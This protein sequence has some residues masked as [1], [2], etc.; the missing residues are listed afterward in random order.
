MKIFT[1]IKTLALVAGMMFATSNANAADKP[2]SGN[3]VVSKVFYAASKGAES[4][5][6][7][8]GQYIEIYNNSANDVDVTGLYIGLIESESKST[9]YTV[10]AIEADADLKTKLNGKV[11]LKQVFQLPTEET[12]I[13]QPGKSILVCNSAIDH[14]ALA[15][16]GHDLSGADY[17]VKTTNAKYTHNDD[18]PALTM[19]YSFNS[20]TD[21][22]NLSYAGPAGVVLL[23]NDAKAIDFENPI[24][25][26]GK[27]KGSQYVIANM[28]YSVDAV[29][30]LANNKTSGIDVTTKRLTDTND[31]GYASTATGGTYNGETV[32]R[33]TAFVMPDGRKVLYDTNNS[34]VDF[35]SSSTIQP[36]AYD[37]ELSGVTEASITIP[38]TG[39]LVFRPETSVF[40]ESDLTF[41]YVTANA[42]NSDLTYNEFKGTDELLANTNF[43]VIGQPGTHKVYYSEAQAS[44]KIPSNAL[45][46]SDED[47]KEF[48]SASQKTRIIY[49][50]V[51]TTEKTGFQRVA[52]TAEGLYN[53]AEFSGDDRLYLYITPAMAT[54][55]FAANGAD[56]ADNLDFLVWHGKKPDLTGVKTVDAAVK[57]TATGA[58]YDINGNKVNLMQKGNVYI[59]D[60]KKVL[61]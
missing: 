43:I 55:F 7:A 19:A 49:K 5:N 33:K 9:A 54:A 39:Y 2:S 42:K 10:E 24:Y 58:I 21:F 25:A 20:S 14:T 27:D 26:L 29:D 36:R 61:K 48:T 16:V 41:T 23:K 40:G 15:V 22:M 37:D 52:K 35:Q 44:K 3:V 30:I 57:A 59:I 45:T 60:G 38:E 1:Q 51:D 56:S 28:Y 46:W 34:S 13:L 31:E 17:E 50:W 8:Y 4:G 47:S 32:Y 12:T 53:Y 18:V 11:V 6:Y